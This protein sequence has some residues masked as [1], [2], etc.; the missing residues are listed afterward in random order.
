LLTVHAHCLA[1]HRHHR[2]HLGHFFHRVL[3][4]L[5]LHLHQGVEHLGLTVGDC[6]ENLGETGRE[7]VSHRRLVD[8]GHFDPELGANAEFSGLRVRCVE[9]ELELSMTESVAQQIKIAFLE[10]FWLE[11]L[12]VFE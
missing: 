8:L 2:Q 5:L 4:R 6:A 7:T 11:P 1:H 3:L 10:L 9:P 12:T